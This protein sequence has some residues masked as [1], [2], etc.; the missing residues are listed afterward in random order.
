MSHGKIVIPISYL[1][2]LGG[3][4]FKIFPTEIGSVIDI[5]N[6]R[7]LVDEIL[8]TSEGTLLPSED[9]EFFI[10]NIPEISVHSSLKRL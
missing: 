10:I 2:S 1:S 7:F 3:L 8:N 6:L 5:G 4:K 9:G